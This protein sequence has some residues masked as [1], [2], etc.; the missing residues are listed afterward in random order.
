MAK[1]H[2]GTSVEPVYN[3]HVRVHGAKPEIWYGVAIV[4]SFVSPA[5]SMWYVV[6][7]VDRL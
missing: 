6:Y 2:V 1:W 3:W 5:L 4:H 7:G